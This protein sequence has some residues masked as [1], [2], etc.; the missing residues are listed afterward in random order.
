MSKQEPWVDQV[1]RDL[2]KVKRAQDLEE[3]IGPLA[4]LRLWWETRRE[5]AAVRSFMRGVSVV[6]VVDADTGKTEHYDNPAP[7]RWLFGG[8]FM[9]KRANTP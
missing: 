1:M 7:W 9:R 5:R 3:R 2:A 8:R 4:K 6:A